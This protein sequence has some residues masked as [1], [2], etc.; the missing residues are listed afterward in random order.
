MTTVQVISDRYEDYV[1]LLAA[2]GV[3]VV[4]RGAEVLLADPALLADIDLAGVRWV[5]STWAGVDAVDWAR[6][7]ATVT[8]TTLP[9]VFG[10]QMAEFVFGHLL[11]WTQ[12]VPQRHA[13][14]TWDESTPSLIAGSTIGILGAGSI[15][16]AIAS[17]AHAF[18]MTVVGCRRTGDSDQAFD[19]MYPI[20]E[21]ESFAR[22]LNHLVVVLPATTK[23]RHL[24]D[25]D[26]LD[27]LAPRSSL[28]NVGRGS[29]VVTDAVVAAVES[30][31]LGLA[32]LDV[33]DPEPLPDDHPAWTIPGIVITGHTAAHSRPEDIA[34]FFGDNLARFTRGQPLVGVVDRS[35][36]Y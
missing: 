26:L 22:G 15:G 30:G 28:I 1:P 31:Q 8:L 33:T 10:P 14:R 6:V 36:G 34:R 27:L 3:E 5:Q 4:D 20:S 16:T 32:V 13:T 2:R 25:A 9:G 18:D 17:V 7:P 12:R 23:T 11:G 35:R 19:R 24:V 21:I 29:T